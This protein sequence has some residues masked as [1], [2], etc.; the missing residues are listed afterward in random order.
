M[1]W[2]VLPLYA[3]CAKKVRLVLIQFLRNIPFLHDSIA[4]AVSKSLDDDIRKPS[5]YFI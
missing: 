4:K 1:M 3:D 5:M 2:I